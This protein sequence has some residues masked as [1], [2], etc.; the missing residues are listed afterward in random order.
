MKVRVS[1]LTSGKWVKNEGMVASYV[2]TKA[3]L[4]VSRARLLGT[5]VKMF[6]AEDGMFA[7]ATLDDGSDTIRAKTFKTVKPL[8]TLGIGDIVDLIGKVKEWNDEIYLIPEIVRKVEPNMEL[9]RRL[10]MLRKGKPAEK[11]EPEKGED[12]EALRNEV[13]KIIESEKEG[14]GYADIISRVKAP[15]ETLEAVI[16]ELLGEG[17]CYEP[18]PGKIRKI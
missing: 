16:N 12:K 15:E 3:G 6:M 1:D 17:V 10:E 7:S 9:L 2:E 5:I 13:M 4:K 18:S 14:I 8:D 11:A